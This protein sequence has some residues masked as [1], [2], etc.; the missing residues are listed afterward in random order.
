VPLAIWVSNRPHAGDDEPVPRHKN[1]FVDKYVAEGTPAEDQIV[2]GWVL[3]TRLLFVI[4]P[5]D[6]LVAWVA[7]IHQLVEA[8]RSSL[9]DLHS[10]IG[11]LNHAA[12]VIPLSR[13]FLGQLRDRL[14]LNLHRNQHIRFGKDEI[15]NLILWESFLA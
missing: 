7:D 9:G 15:A 8:G 14:H 10:L 2:L 3:D 6:K 12:Y 1:V 13:H 5:A 4:L 11:R